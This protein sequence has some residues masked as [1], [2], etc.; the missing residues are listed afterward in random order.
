MQ[1]GN[2][3]SG[4]ILTR[5]LSPA[6]RGEV[7]ALMSIVLTVTVVAGL[8]YS[9][10]LVFWLSRT[11]PNNH[12]Y[13]GSGFLVAIVGGVFGTAA[14]IALA[15][16]L[17][18]IAH[19][20]NTQLWPWFLYPVVAQIA[21]Y[22]VTVAQ[23]MEMHKRWAFLRVIATANYAILLTCFA[24]AHALHIKNIGFA[25]VGG[26]LLSVVFSI[27]ALSGSF[28]PSMI[29]REALRAI[30]VYAVRLHPASF[31]SLAR[32]QLDKVLLFY[33][34]P[35]SDLGWYVAGIALGLV[36][37]AAAQTID[38][39]IFPVLV[40]IVDPEERKKIC[41]AQMRVVSALI[42]AGMIVMLPLTPLAVRILFGPE[43]AVAVGVPTAAAAIGF[44]Q[45]LRVVFN[46]GLKIEHR[47]GALGLNELIGTVLSLALMFPLV[48]SLGIY[49]APIASAIGGSFALGLTIRK[50]KDI[51]AV[52]FREILI[53]HARDITALV[54]RLFGSRPLQ[55]EE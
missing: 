36:P 45:S 46:V 15:P 4:V 10:A 34:V 32:E 54:A 33:F 24:L 28:R 55:V 50:I 38:Q 53:P 5:A 11:K 49:G 13:V 47:P 18:H 27:I 3:V 51:Y 42:L 1:L 48:V 35:P 39:V 12:R 16:V 31:T 41:L 17:R 2:L 40:S 20:A 25:V 23:G 22:F 14:L 7:A 44:L 37:V 26:Q 21:L 43:Y 9:D 29:D 19:T 52:S 8:S 6:A 30:Y